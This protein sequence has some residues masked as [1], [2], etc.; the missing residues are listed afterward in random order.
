MPLVNDAGLDPNN[1][2]YDMAFD[3]RKL[4]AGLIPAIGNKYITL[5]GSFPDGSGGFLPQGALALCTATSPETWVALHAPSGMRLA[6]SSTGL[7]W[8][9]TAVANTWNAVEG[10]LDIVADPSQADVS[11][12]LNTLIT[13]A[14]AISFSIPIYLGPTTF[15]GGTANGWRIQAQINNADNNP[16]ICYGPIVWNTATIPFGNTCAVRVGRNTKIVGYNSPI[17]SYYW[18]VGDPNPNNYQYGLNGVEFMN[19]GETFA[20]AVAYNFRIGVN[21]IGDND[22]RTMTAFGC[23]TNHIELETYGCLKS[24]GWTCQN[25]PSF[26]NENYLYYSDATHNDSTVTTHSV[27]VLSCKFG[28]AGGEANGNKWYAGPSDEAAVA[29][30]APGLY[31]F[32]EIIT[33]PMATAGAGLL[34]NE[35]HGIRIDTQ[36][37]PTFIYFAN[38]PPA[39]VPGATVTGNLFN[40]AYVRETYWPI[41]AGV[42]GNEAAVTAC[43]FNTFEMPYFEPHA[44]RYEGHPL[45]KIG[46][47]NMTQRLNSGSLVVQAPARGKFWL[48]QSMSFANE[49]N[50]NYG[51]L[52]ANSVQLAPLGVSFLG[53]FIDVRNTPFSFLNKMLVKANLNS[54]PGGR[55]TA[56]VYKPDGTVISSA[57]DFQTYS[58]GTLNAF[59]YGGASVW[60]MGGDMTLTTSAVELAWSQNVGFLFVGVSGGTVQAD[61]VDIEVFAPGDS[62]ATLLTNSMAM[63]VLG[64]ALPL[65]DDDLPYSNGTP[66]DPVTVNISAVTPGATTQITTATANGY[67]VGTPVYFNGVVGIT[68]LNGVMANV[69]TVTSSTVFTVNVATSGTYTSGGTAQADFIPRGQTVRAMLPAG[70]S[71]TA[72][73]WVR[74]ASDTW[75]ARNF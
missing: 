52:T 20:V 26:V 53:V 43:A 13:N 17:R 31:N 47:S 40:F 23:A 58:G 12:A 7:I 63:P 33:D 32:I 44:G 42:T 34:A 28:P 30:S 3:G 6:D 65:I 69:A 9:R 60:G 61:L 41:F 48:R 2:T 24:V 57:S 62:G 45:V 68:G 39:G 70:T 11:T 19:C 67:A 1:V 59:T 66:A 21:L 35:F 72:A 49:T 56:I 51:Q 25:G 16:M 29:S 22:G 74:T 64:P 46:R 36:I 5:D 50:A 75:V 10:W 38:T 4:H 14:A 8:L 27:A 55:L 73:E 37:N 15:P 71:G 54:A 18:V